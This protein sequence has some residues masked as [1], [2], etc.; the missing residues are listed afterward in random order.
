MVIPA[1]VGLLVWAV[2]DRG[3]IPHQWAPL[4]LVTPDDWWEPAT[5][6]NAKDERGICA[7]FVYKRLVLVL[8]FLAMARLGSWG[9]A[10]RFYFA[11][12]PQPKRALL[13][14]AGPWSCSRSSSPRPTRARSGTPSR[15]SRR[16]AT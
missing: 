13:A 10:A 14:L 3:G 6:I 2:F 11:R 4:R 15:S 5:V 7:F 1:V 16:S 12:H 9:R 8:L